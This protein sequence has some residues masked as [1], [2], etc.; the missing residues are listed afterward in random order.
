VESSVRSSSAS[1]GTV[2]GCREKDTFFVIFRGAGAIPGWALLGGAER[3]L[4]CEGIS[5]VEHIF[6]EG[7]EADE[8]TDE[9][10][11]KMESMEDRTLDERDE[12]EFLRVWRTAWTIVGSVEKEAYSMCDWAF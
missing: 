4:L 2:E 8:E 11:E 7:T 3:L 5:A 12:T 6:A 10:C 1:E 9:V